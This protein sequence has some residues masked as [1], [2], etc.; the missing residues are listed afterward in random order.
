M[1]IFKKIE[2]EIDKN[3]EK[4]YSNVPKEFIDNQKMIV[5]QDDEIIGACFYETEGHFCKLNFVY[6]IE[7]DELIK[8]GLIRT[9]IN[10]MDIQ[11]ITKI[12][13]TIASDKSFYAKIGF[14]P[15]LFTDFVIDLKRDKS[16]YL[17]LDTKDFFKN[18]C[19][20]S[21]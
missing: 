17:I 16:N 21:K 7:Q 6:I 14:N 13:A 10:A 8:D 3:I 4:L 12:I 15:L 5:K 2:E 18:T 19:C 11:E 9:L 20:S 1:L